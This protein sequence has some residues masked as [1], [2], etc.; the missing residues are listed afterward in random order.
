M[1]EISYPNKWLPNFVF[2][3]KIPSTLAQSVTYKLGNYF[4]PNK[5]VLAMDLEQQNPKIGSL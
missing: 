1:M 5:C 2:K 4:N 3:I